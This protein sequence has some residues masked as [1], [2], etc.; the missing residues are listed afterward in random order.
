MLEKTLKSPLESKEI[1][2]ADPKGNQSSIVIGRTVLKLKFQY[3][4]HLMQR[5][6]SLGKTLML[7][8]MEDKRRRGRQRMR[9]WDGITDPVNMGLSKL[10]ETVKNREAWRAAVHGVTKSQTQLRDYTTSVLRQL[11]I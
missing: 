6:D 11:I 8:K 3:F 9:W 5:A 10:W 4:G 1:K 2:T 7:G